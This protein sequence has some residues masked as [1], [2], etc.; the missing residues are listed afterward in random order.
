M[1][2]IVSY[3]AYVP[4]YRLKR[5]TIFA[6]MGWL[7][8][9]R[10][11]GEKAIANDDED[12]VTMAVA[13]GTDCLGDMGRDKVD[14]LYLATTTAPYRERQDGVIVASALNLRTD[15]R[16]ADFTDTTRAGTVALLTACDTVKAGSAGNVLVCSADCRPAKAGGSEEQIYGDAGASLLVGNEGVVASLEGSY[17]VAHDFMGH[18]R[19]EHDR[20]EHASEDRFSRDIGY[21]GF[22]T[23]AILG[24]LK[25]HN[26]KMKDVAKVVYP[27]PYAREHSAIGKKIGAEANQLQDPMLNSIGDAGAAQP[28]L[29]LVAA[30]EEAKPGDLLVVAGFGAGADAVLLRV[31]DRI[32]KQQGKSR[33]K[34][35]LNSKKYLENYEKYIAF[36]NMLPV[37]VGGRGEEVVFTQVT[38]LFR[39]RKLIL[40]LVGS[41]CKNCCTPQ[42]PPQRVCVK[43]GCGSIDHMEDYHF[44]DKK[45]KVFT[46]TGDSLQFAINPPAI[47]GVIDFDGG[48]RFW[49]DFCDCVLESLKV[50]MPVEMSFRRRYLD[51]KRGIH[52]YFWK[53]AP[54]RA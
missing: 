26:I 53:A 43:P 52:G 37:E 40:G 42:Y 27:G 11:K 49:F 34:S 19:S 16:V 45:G 24:L 50:G 9:A 12:S 3:G 6:A 5:D 41:R 14:G 8:N 47:Y 7:N 30:L 4:W 35:Y 15:V 54:V 29:M 33:F 25:K 20:F 10:L 48:G 22:I 17:S 36:R 39:E 23:E 31:T 21:M 2:G 46:Y 28:L 1:T 51:E 32:V 13:A 44:A 38:R 18:W